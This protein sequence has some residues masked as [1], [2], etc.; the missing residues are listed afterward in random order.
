MR[1][2]PVSWCE[3]AVVASYDHINVHIFLFL[4]LR[5]ERGMFVSVLCVKINFLGFLLFPLDCNV[6]LL[7]IKEWRNLEK[8][9]SFVVQGIKIKFW[10]NHFW[11]NS[12]DWTNKIKRQ[13]Y[14]TD[15]VLKK[16]NF[17]VNA[18]MLHDFIKIILFSCFINWFKTRKKL[19]RIF[20]F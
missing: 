13:P 15:F 16:T 9:L 20:L 1:T 18:S 19:S 2:K 8:T 12:Y 11:Q 14:K 3:N 5:E 7:P 6:A 4:V 17:V 10:G